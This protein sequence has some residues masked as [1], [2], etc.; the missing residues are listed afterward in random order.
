MCSTIFFVRSQD[1]SGGGR[2][3]RQYATPSYSS[4][5]SW[6][7]GQSRKWAWTA[8]LRAPAP[9]RISSHNASTSRQRMNV[10]SSGDDFSDLRPEHATKNSHGTMDVRFDRADRLIQNLGDLGMTAAF[11]EAQRRSGAQMHR[12]L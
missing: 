7:G 12:K 5:K 2:H 3:E 10:S 8:S 11:D 6:H 4:Y 1:G 9:S